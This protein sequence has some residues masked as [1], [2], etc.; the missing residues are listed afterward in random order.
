MHDDNRSVDLPVQASESFVL[1]TLYLEK[2]E[3]TQCHFNFLTHRRHLASEWS[4]DCAM[5]V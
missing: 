3:D 5:S 1:N 2:V 4:A